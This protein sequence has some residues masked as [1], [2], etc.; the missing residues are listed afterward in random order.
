MSEKFV[1]TVLVDHLKRELAL[2]KEQAPG[3]WMAGF[4]EA[5]GRTIDVIEGILK[6]EPAGEPTVTRTDFTEPP[7][8]GDWQ[9]HAVEAG[10]D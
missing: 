6:P 10:D 8:E 5:H 7:A 1:L 2:A 3:P 4:V 9:L